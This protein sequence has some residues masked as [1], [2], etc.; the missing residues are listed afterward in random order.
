MK[1]LTRRSAFTLIELLVVIA[2]IAILIGLL[3]PAVQKVRDAAA[4]ME[5]TANLKEIG[6]A[7]LNYES[8][9]KR[10]P[11]GDMGPPPPASSAVAIYG[12]YTYIGV[13]AQILPYVEQDNLF[14]KLLPAPL[15]T[16]AGTT[17][18]AGF[19]GSNGN[20]WAAA[21]YQVPVFQC[22]VDN[23]LTRTDVFILPITYPTTMTGYYYAGQPTLGRTSYMGVGGYLGTGAGYDQYAGIF[24]TGTNISMPRLTSADGS[25]NTLMFG[26]S[27]G[28][29]NFSYSWMGWGWMPTGWGLSTT[30]QWYTFNSKHASG[31]VNFCF[32][33]GS[34]RQVR[35]SVSFTVYLYASGY[36]EGG[37]YSTNDL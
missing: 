9:F 11:C 19:W 23:P 6:L 12:N 15:M 34:V 17:D 24:T 25:S 14:K 18:P 28:S 1:R 22:P 29:G 7:A 3:L 4:R 36:N 32:G 30:P 5:C 20:Y 10:F 21:N 27:V 8:T 31:S 26:E 13:L 16:P 2:I 37:V 35:P 33:D